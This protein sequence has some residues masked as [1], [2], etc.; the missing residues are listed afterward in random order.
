MI[1]QAIAAMDTP[2]EDAWIRAARA[3]IGPDLFDAILNPP[4]IDPGRR[5]KKKEVN[6]DA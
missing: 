1:C 3:Y 2:E 5:A 4:P 6:F